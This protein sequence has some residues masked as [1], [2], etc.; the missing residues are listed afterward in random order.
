MSRLSHAAELA[1][2]AIEADVRRRLFLGGLAGSA[3]MFAARGLRAETYKPFGNAETGPDGITRTTLEQHSFEA[4]G[5]EFRMV[6]NEYPPGVGLPVHHHPGVGINYVLEGV[7]ES[8][9]ADEE[10]ISKFTVGQSYQ[11]K[12]DIPHETFRNPDSGS[13]L[14][15]LII[16]TVK[17]GQPFLIIP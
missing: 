13:P 1:L 7:A 6:L 16:Y 8:R 10:K 14:K 12:P 3:A 5:E 17:R 9:Y 2:P 4:T 11:D 15:Y